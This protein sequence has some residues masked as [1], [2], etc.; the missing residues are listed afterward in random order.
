MF[1]SGAISWH[2]VHRSHAT[3]SQDIIHQTGNPA[4]ALETLYT[5][6]LQMAYYDILSEYDISSPARWQV[7]GV[8]NIPHHWRAFSVI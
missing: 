7:L 1:I 6:L 5:I 4:L 3:I 2:S 8:L